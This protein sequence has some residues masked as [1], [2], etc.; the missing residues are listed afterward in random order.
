MS[1]CVCMYSL[2]QTGSV[3]HMR[4]GAA[5]AP[6]AAAAAAATAATVT[7]LVMALDTAAAITTQTGPKA[8]TSTSKHAM[9][10]LVSVWVYGWA[11]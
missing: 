5:Q 9:P 4:L 8:T 7:G 3:L 6:T 11:H 10:A 2:P 1:D